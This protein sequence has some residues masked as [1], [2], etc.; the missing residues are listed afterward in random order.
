MESP[1]AFRRSTNIGIPDKI[2]RRLKEN[3]FKPKNN[4]FKNKITIYKGV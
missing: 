2:F 4:K 3:P 1:R